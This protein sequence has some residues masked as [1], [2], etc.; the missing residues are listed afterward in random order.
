MLV[1]SVD[2]ILPSTTANLVS[3]NLKLGIILG[4]LKDNLQLYMLEKENDEYL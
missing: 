1:Q 4:I 3:C 2:R